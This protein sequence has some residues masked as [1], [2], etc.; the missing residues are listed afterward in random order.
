MNLV[1]RSSDWRRRV[2][3]EKVLRWL[4]VCAI[5]TSMLPPIDLVCD[6]CW[7]TL[8]RIRN[9]ADGPR[10]LLQTGYP[11]PVHSLFT[12]TP[13][14]DHVLR[15]LIHAL[16]QGRSPMAVE[17][18]G[19]WFAFERLRLGNCD[20]RAIVPAPGRS[21]DHAKAWAETLSKDFRL[22]I[23]D[24]LQKAPGQVRFQRSRSAEER[25]EL[26]FHLDL[27]SIDVQNAYRG[28]Y[29]FADDVITTGSTAMAAYMALGDPKRFEVWTMVN[30]PRLAAPG[31]L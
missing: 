30:R 21:F 14:T 15:P 24:V 11:F 7:E 2:A 18:L 27:P 9:Q 5:C 28:P 31:A 29:L 17:R 1:G 13:K 19:N 22:P 4:R 12:W 8:R 3:A 16:K 20:F 10:G 6:E 23:M 26:R 25:S